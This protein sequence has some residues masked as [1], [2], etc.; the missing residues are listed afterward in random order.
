MEESKQRR[1]INGYRNKDK[2]Y[3]KQAI[4]AAKQ[5]LYGPEVILKI[6]NAKD[7]NEIEKI[8]R[9]ARLKS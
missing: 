7:N 4:T 5:L 1:C 3:K 9:N 2:D 6:K 8:M